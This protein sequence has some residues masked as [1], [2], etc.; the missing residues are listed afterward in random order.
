[1]KVTYKEEQLKDELDERIQSALETSP[2][3]FS[4]VFVE[5]EAKLQP[6]MVEE[7]INEEERETPHAAML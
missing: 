2:E 3:I 7:K 6:P 1:M 5:R 4:I